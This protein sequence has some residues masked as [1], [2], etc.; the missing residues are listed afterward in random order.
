MLKKISKVLFSRLIIIGMLIIIQV[1]WIVILAYRISATFTYASALIKIVAI[2]TALRI[3]NKRTNPTMKLAWTFIILAVPVLG[4]TVYLIF[5]RS[6]LNKKMRI[7]FERINKE[8]DEHLKGDEALRKRL[9]LLDSNI[10]NQSEYIHKWAEFPLYEN[11]ST[12]YFSSGEDMFVSMKE[13]LEKAK[14]YIFLEYFI[15]EQGHM[16]DS[17]LEILERKI[18]SGVE[19]RLIYDDVGCISTLP[20]RYY[21]LLQKKGIKCAAFNPFRPMLS[22]IMNNRDHRKILVI[23]GYI[24]YTGG[25][26]LADEYINNIERYG[27][28]KDTGIRLEGEAVWSF[29]AMFL[30]MWNSI[31]HTD[32]PQDYLKYKPYVYHEE[33]FASDGWVQ[34][35]CDSPLDREIVGENVYLNMIGRAKKYVYIFTPYLVTD[36][37]L[38]T[39]LCIAAKSGVDVRIVIPGIPDKKIVYWVGESYFSRFIEAGIKLYRFKPGFIHAKCFVCDDEVATVGTFNMDYRSLYLHFECGV[40]LYQSK[41]VIQ[42]KT[43]ML[44]TFEQSELITEEECKNRFWIVRSVQELFILFAPLL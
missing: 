35:Y 20:N 40:W 9:E 43:D 39:S 44:K 22:I 36:N 37:E 38:I 13:D 7:R 17:I 11:T 14:Q 25:V 4:L 21:K 16:W 33:G 31:T 32:T 1:S 2:I 26:N 18:K 3:A 41:A 6:D 23:D 19:V 10:S 15:I 27:Y 30:E 8:F 12:E 24:G 42:M 5:G 28:W 29:T 34:P